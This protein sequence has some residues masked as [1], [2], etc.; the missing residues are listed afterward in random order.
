M[1]SASTTA[2]TRSASKPL[3]A[4]VEID[5]TRDAVVSLGLEHVATIIQICSR[6][7]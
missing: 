2:T 4:K 5:K 1:S 6:R 3:H 7:R